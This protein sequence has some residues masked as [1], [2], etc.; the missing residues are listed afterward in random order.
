MTELS[1]SGALARPAEWWRR[2]LAFCVDGVLVGI[3]G[4]T[5]GFTVS[6][7]L[8]Q[9]GA[10]GRLVGFLLTLAYF[11]IMNSRLTNGQSLGKRLLRIRVVDPQGR[12]LSVARSFLRFVPLGVPWFLNNAAFPES[13]LFS[14]WVYLLSIAVFGLG[15]SF[16]FLFLFDRPWRR[17]LDDLLAGS[18]VIRSA[19]NGAVGAL[20]P[21]RWQLATCA[22]LIVAA[23][24]LPVFTGRLATSETFGP[25]LKVHQAVSAEPWVAHAQVDRGTNHNSNGTITYMAIDAYLRDARIQ[26]PERAAQLARIAV[27][28]DPSSRSL[29]VL[30]V[31]LVY[32]FDIGIAE[33]SRSQV[34]SYLPKDVAQ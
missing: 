30:Q 24:L 26:D 32:G 27:T 4:L 12:P 9:L 8:A 22:V 7:Q 14:F 17:S 13:V 16:I 33:A 25:L 28:Q 20:A 34:F 6:D 11:G 19:E 31:T 1:D 15:L 29:D 2:I 21:R 5:L 23:G 3:V 18:V 10:W